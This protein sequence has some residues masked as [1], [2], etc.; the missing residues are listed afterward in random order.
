MLQ[1]IGKTGEGSR[2]GYGYE[3]RRGRVGGWREQTLGKTMEIWE[4]SGMSQRNVNSQE[5]MRMSL[6]KNPR[7]QDTE[8]E[9]AISCNR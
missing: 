7:K 5:S 2:W 8:P 9:A 4:I 6:A 1:S 3:S